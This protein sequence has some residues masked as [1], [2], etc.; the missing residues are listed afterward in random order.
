MDINANFIENHSRYFIEP[1]RVVPELPVREWIGGG[2][3][4]HFGAAGV[5]R[6]PP[7]A[8][9]VGSRHER[10]RQKYRLPRPNSAR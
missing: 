6:Q 10:H 7:P 8:S 5:R 1:R 4:D 3:Y 2:G 9:T